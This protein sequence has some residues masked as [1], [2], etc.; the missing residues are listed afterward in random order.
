MAALKTLHA[1]ESETVPAD[2]FP[3]LSVRQRTVMTMLLDGLARKQIA[4][5]LQISEE[6][7]ANHIKMIF[8]HFQVHSAGEL[9]AL[10]LKGR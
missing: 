9:A 1:D 2:V 4:Q 6:T 3:E 7:V 10:F 8:K 5:R